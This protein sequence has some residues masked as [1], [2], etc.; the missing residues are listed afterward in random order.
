MRKEVQYIYIHYL[1]RSFQFI[2]TSAHII[3]KLMSKTLS[4][5]KSYVK[6]M[7]VMFHVT[8][9]VIKY[10][11]DIYI[12]IFLFRKFDLCRLNCLRRLEHENKKVT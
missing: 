3:M 7:S 4:R 6:Y 1:H 11:F 8:A 10:H 5:H 12:Y 2:H 9:I